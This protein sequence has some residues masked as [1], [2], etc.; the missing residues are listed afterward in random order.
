MASSTPP[1][2]KQS[3]IAIIGAGVFGLSIAIHLAQRGFINVTVF[4]KQPYWETQYDFDAG[5]DAASAG[6][7]LLGSHFPSYIA[8]F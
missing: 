2:D 5:C 7:L 6:M 8:F 4:D 3:P 1:A